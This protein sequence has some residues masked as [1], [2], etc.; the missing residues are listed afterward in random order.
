[1]DPNPGNVKLHITDA[2]IRLAAYD[3]AYGF[4]AAKTFAD[5]LNQ[6]FLGQC[7][8]PFSSEE[9][10]DAVTTFKVNGCLVLAVGMSDM[11]FPSEQADAMLCRCD[12]LI[13]RFDNLKE[14]GGIASSGDDLLRLAKNHATNL[15][16]DSQIPP[17]ESRL[18]R[19]MFVSGVAPKAK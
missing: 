9:V 18:L 11:G 10:F 4:G 12:E 5:A 3:R 19:G 13:K 2:G 8:L 1:M 17:Y 6:P 7:Q 14:G 16:S 15:S